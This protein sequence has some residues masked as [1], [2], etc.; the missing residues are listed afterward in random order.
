MDLARAGGRV[1][2]NTAGIR[3]FLIL[4]LEDEVMLTLPDQGIEEVLL[5]ESLTKL[6]LDFSKSNRVPN[7]TSF[8]ALT[9][10]QSH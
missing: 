5:E 3:G 1:F 9:S 8:Q 6:N 2:L 7:P 10:G 4:E